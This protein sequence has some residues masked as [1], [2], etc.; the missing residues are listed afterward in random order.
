M[1]EVI[2][3][4]QASTTRGVSAGGST[5]DT[6]SLKSIFAKSPIHAD[7][8]GDAEAKAVMLDSLTGVTTVPG[9]GDV[10]MNYIHAD[11]PDLRSVATGGGGLPASPF[12]PNPASSP[13][14]KASDQPAPPEGFGATPT[15][16]GYGNGP[17]ANAT[18]RN[19]ILSA[20]RVKR[21]SLRYFR[22]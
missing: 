12:V 5:S 11:S 9:L 14:G 18:K 13:S 1:S 10:N 6:A 20:R 22:A 4:G 15:S 21:M 19:P 8:Y 16:D 3:D 7:T 2:I 17:T